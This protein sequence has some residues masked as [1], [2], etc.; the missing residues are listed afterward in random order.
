[1]T[2]D[3]ERKFTQDLTI[4]LKVCEGLEPPKSVPRQ[5]RDGWFQRRAEEIAK[6]VF[7]SYRLT[8]RPFDHF[9]GERK[10]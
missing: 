8:P 4:W 9:T 10:D 2:D 3:I 7:H 6:K 5:H 1:M